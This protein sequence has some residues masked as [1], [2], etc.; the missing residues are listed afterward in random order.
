MLP[1]YVALQGRARPARDAAR[2][3][4]RSCLV[5]GT[6]GKTTTTA[7]VAAALGDDVATN[8]DGANLPA[9]WV[10]T[11]LDSPPAPGRSCSR[12][13]S[14]TCPPRSTPRPRAVA[15]LL[16]LS[17]DQLDRHSET[18][19]LALRWRD[20]LAAHPD[21]RGGGQR[22]RSAR[23]V[24]RER[25]HRRHVGR[26]R[27]RVAQRRG[28]VPGVRR[29]PGPHRDLVVVPRV[30]ARAPGADDRD[31]AVSGCASPAS[32]TRTRSR[33]PA[34][35]TAATSR[36][37]SARRGALG[38][39][40]E[41]ALDA[42]GRVR[43]VSGR[44]ARHRVDGHEVILLLAKNPAGWVETLDVIDDLLPDGQGT[45]VVAINARGPDGRDP[46]VAVG[47][48]RSSSSRAAR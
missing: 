9:G 29:A 44:Y 26:G 7:L 21:V 36:S 47:R 31:A 43:E 32:T 27:R 17:R 1:G 30:R 38:V 16:N 4:A 37:R 15:A 19:M 5:S 3:S 23:R 2:R 13:T 22:R 40:T 10:S 8:R 39:P 41:A 28:R 33:C 45:V 6:N 24:G 11:L 48:A 14:R 35:P 46:V 12:S 18:R 34:A 20:T 42:V 25:G